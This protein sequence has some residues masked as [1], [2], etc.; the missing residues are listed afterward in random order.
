MAALARCSSYLLLAPLHS[1]HLCLCVL[2]CLWWNQPA[3]YSSAIQLTKLR[4][5]W[6]ICFDQVCKALRNGKHPIALR[7]FRYAL[8]AEEAEELKQLVDKKML[9]TDPNVVKPLGERWW[10][11]AWCQR[12]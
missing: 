9:G 6:Y 4:K 3:A 8:T 7:E 2:A 11:A 1:P 10:S 12:C 5:V